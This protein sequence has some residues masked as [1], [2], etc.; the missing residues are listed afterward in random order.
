M[1]WK[2]Q[3]EFRP[4]LDVCEAY[5]ISKTT[6]Y[7]LMKSNK[8]NT[9]TIG[10]RRMVMIDSVKALAHAAMRNAATTR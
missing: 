10:R 3:V 6:I 5:G 9:F 4:L 7:K 2:N 8:L 1:S